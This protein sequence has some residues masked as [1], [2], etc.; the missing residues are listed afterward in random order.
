MACNLHYFIILFYLYPVR[1]RDTNLKVGEA[2]G[3]SLCYSP[4]NYNTVIWQ[5]FIVILFSDES[6][7]MLHENMFV[8]CNQY[9][10]Q[11]T[12]RNRK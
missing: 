12:S 5:I 10:S 6:E 11:L 1:G 4:D 9:S 7:Y 2:G 8:Y 3:E